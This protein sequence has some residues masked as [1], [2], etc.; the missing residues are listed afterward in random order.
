[1]PDP[2]ATLRERLS[3]LFSRITTVLSPNR[4]S[5]GGA[6]IRAIVIHTTEGS[7]RGT[8]EWFK[9]EGVNV[10]SH[11][12][13]SDFDTGGDFTE[14][15]RMV[16]EGEKAWTALSANPTT[17]NYELAGFAARTRA[18]W[19]GPYRTQLDT[20]AALVAEDTL[21]HG[22]P[23]VHGYPGI[24]GHVDLTR[25]G[26]PQ[27]H[28]DPGPGFPWDVFLD[29]VHGFRQLGIAPEPVELTVR[30][31][32][33]PADAPTRIPKWAWRLDR[34]QFHRLGGTEPRPLHPVPI[35]SWYWPWRAWLHGI[36]SHK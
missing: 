18:E 30:Q 28:W 32:N 14:V 24:L 19:L 16:P 20:V 27:T 4:S 10:S 3:S 33:R 6:P 5:R 11:Y 35:P 8:I 29:R 9:R 26:F 25:Y 2:A 22:I 7:Y 23:V 36:G 1:M 21:E 31:R 17:I 15:T 34:W 12:V 13:V